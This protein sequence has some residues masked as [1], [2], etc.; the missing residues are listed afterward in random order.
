[1]AA[2]GAAKYDDAIAAFSALEQ[3]AATT[4]PKMAGL[5]AY[6][7]GLVLAKTGKIDDAVVQFDKAVQLDPAMTEAYYQK[8]TALIA[9]AT[10]DKAGKIIAPPGTAEAFQKYLELAPNGKNAESAA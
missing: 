9:K 10:A 3:D 6:D 7:H 5:A 8:G 1:N 2:D 4:N